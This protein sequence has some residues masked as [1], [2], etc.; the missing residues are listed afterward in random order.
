MQPTDTV[1]SSATRATRFV[2][3]YDSIWLPCS[4]YT[5]IAPTTPYFQ[6]VL[7]EFDGASPVWFM[8][9][10]K[11]QCI[12]QSLEEHA[13]YK[14]TISSINVQAQEEMNTYTIKGGRLSSVPELLGELISRVVPL[15][16]DIVSVTVTRPVHSTS[17]DPTPSQLTAFARSEAP[18]VLLTLR[19]WSWDGHAM[20]APADLGRS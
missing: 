6:S 9:R 2:Q 12:L 7:S 20:L 11:C 5:S 18:S 10:Q 3:Q 13:L 8:Y 17:K 1:L 14:L 19:D 16:T 4:N 15:D